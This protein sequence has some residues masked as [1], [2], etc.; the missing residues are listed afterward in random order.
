MSRCL[1]LIILSAIGLASA[2]A[3]LQVYPQDLLPV[4]ALEKLEESARSDCSI[5][6]RQ[7]QKE[8]FEMLSFALD[9]GRVIQTTSACLLT[10]D[11]SGASD[12]LPGRYSPDCAGPE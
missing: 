9:P 2:F 12:Q 4:E 6:A 7:L 5:C 1:L 3:G 11:P 8:A 10:R